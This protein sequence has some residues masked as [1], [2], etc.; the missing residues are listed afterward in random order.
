MLV[1]ALYEMLAVPEGQWVDDAITSQTLCDTLE[2]NTT[3]NS[4]EDTRGP[5][6]RQSGSLAGLQ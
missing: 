4:I 6:T 2:E 5:P 1:D 3:V